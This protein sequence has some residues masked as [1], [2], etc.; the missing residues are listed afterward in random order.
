MRLEDHSG[1]KESGLWRITK[2]F[3]YFLPYSAFRGILWHHMCKEARSFLDVGC[4]TGEVMQV[5]NL[6]E[7]EIYRVGVDIFRPSLEMCHKNRIYDE[8]ILCD[9]R[10]LPF[11]NKSFDVA[12]C[13]EVI[14]H[15]PKDDGCRLIEKLEELSLKQVLF[16]LPVNAGPPEG[17]LWDGNVFQLHRSGWTFE[18]FGKEGYKVRGM[19][20]KFPRAG[21]MCFYDLSYVLPSVLIVYFRPECAHHVIC[22]KSF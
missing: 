2:K 22:T 3:V 11:R 7:T 20:P 10:H 15:L 12:F 6:H 8:V 13:V 5:V 4:G 1:R 17:R 18:E 14:E 9:I 19:L 16:E 21:Y